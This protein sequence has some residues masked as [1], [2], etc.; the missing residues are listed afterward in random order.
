MTE[1][2][3]STPQPPHK[4]IPRP[5]RTALDR[6]I[7]F[8][9]QGFGTGCIP[10]AP[11]TFGT[12]AGFLWIWLLLLP[13]KLWLYLAGIVAGFFISVWIGGRAEKMLGAKDPGS[14][15][16]DEIA[17]LPLAFLPAVIWTSDASTVQSLPEYFDRKEILLPLLVFALFRLFDIAKPL[18]ISRSQNFPRGWG[19]TADDF[20]AALAAAILLAAYLAIQY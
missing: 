12:A 3:E 18:G 8:I 5:E 11:G 16:I 13:G 6:S 17:A 2:E 9:A 7:L 1:T 14:I 19:L 10:V 15:V 4:R 20:L